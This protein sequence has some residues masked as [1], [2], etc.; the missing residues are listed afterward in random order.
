[1]TAARTELLAE[2]AVYEELDPT[3]GRRLW[4]RRVE[5]DVD[6]PLVH[7]WMHKPHVEEFW[8]MAWPEAWIHDY[9]ARHYEAP[10]RTAYLG[11]VD[12]E[13]V[14]YMEVYDPATDVV[15]TCYA[16]QPG[17]IGAHVLIGEEEH[18]GR[19]SVALGFAVNRFLFRRPGVQRIIGEPDVR[20]HNFLS[21]LAFLGF[22][23]DREIDMPDKRA[24][25]M[26][27]ERATFERL[28]SRRHRVEVRR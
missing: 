8:H 2:R 10:D 11:F 3:I 13:P 17:D 14:G 4:G 5:P 9:L 1:M 12:D 28:T 16:V 7:A 23:K 21:L 19:L 20:N 27:C 24:A 18:L 26:V 25:L 22:R 15:G 6:T